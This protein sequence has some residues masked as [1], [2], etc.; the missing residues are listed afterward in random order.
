M[1]VAFRLAFTTVNDALGARPDRAL[2][3]EAPREIVESVTFGRPVDTAPS[4]A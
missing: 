3:A 2:A 4:A 1:L